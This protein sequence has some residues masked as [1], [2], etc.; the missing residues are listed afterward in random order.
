MMEQNLIGAAADHVTPIEEIE[1]RSE[2]TFS[3]IDQPRNP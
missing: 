1:T 3:L 2:L